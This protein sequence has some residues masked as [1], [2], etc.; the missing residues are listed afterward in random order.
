MNALRQQSYRILAVTRFC[1]TGEFSGERFDDVEF[2][3]GP[4]TARPPGRFKAIAISNCARIMQEG[5]A[6]AEP[7]SRP[8]PR[9]SSPLGR[10]L[11]LAQR[12]LRRLRSQ[13]P[14]SR[15]ADG[16]TSAATNRAHS[17]IATTE[18]DP[19]DPGTAGSS[20]GMLRR[21]AVDPR[22]SPDL[23]HPRPTRHQGSRITNQRSCAVIAFIR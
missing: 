13:S 22:P 18:I 9:W 19:R 17:N 7:R 23:H 3:A 21:N 1:Q 14:C 4:L 16:L 15:G 5:D 10:N 2:P 6:A 20:L 8:R 11:A 12:S